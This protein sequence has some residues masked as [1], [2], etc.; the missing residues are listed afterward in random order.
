MGIPETISRGFLSKDAC[1]HLEVQEFVTG[2]TVIEELRFRRGTT[3]GSQSGGKGV[4]VMPVLLPRL[5]L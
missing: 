1:F 5:A 4:V 2:W 3:Y